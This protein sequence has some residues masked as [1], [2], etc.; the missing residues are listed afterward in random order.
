MQIPHCEDAVIELQKLRG[1]SLDLEHSNGKHKAR[2][3]FEKLG[4]IQEDAEYL[5]N[6]ILDAV[7]NDDASEAPGNDYGQLYTLDFVMKTEKGQA[8]VRTG[9]IIRNNEDFPRL[10]SCYVLP[11]K[12]VE[13]D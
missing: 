1:Y 9:W 4:L 8:Y 13:N 7:C 5:R 2:I 12:R 3:F 6:A 11:R 10:T